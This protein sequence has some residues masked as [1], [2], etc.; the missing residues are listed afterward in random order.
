[1]KQATVKVIATFLAISGVL[2]S[3]L[4]A[5]TYEHSGDSE[6]PRL[7]LLQAAS[8]TPATVRPP[9]ALCP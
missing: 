2:I 8:G 7:W 6:V 3:D 9:L 5:E 4:L 1:M